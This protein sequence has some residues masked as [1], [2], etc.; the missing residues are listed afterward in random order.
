M[1]RPVLR[2]LSPVF[3][4]S[5]LAALSCDGPPG[6]LAP[7]VAALETAAPAT[8]KPTAVAIP[9]SAPLKAGKPPALLVTTDPERAPEPLGL[10]SV[11]VA[12]VIDGFLAETTT[13][14]TFRN[15]YPRV[16]EGELVFPLPEGATISGYALD[17]AGEMV[18]G[19]AVERHEARIAFEKEVRRGVDPGLVEWVKG[20]NFRTRVWPIPAHGA[21]TVRVRYV[22]ELVTRSRGGAVDAFYALPLRFGQSIADL[23]LKVEVVKGLARPELRSGAPPAFRFEAWE[24]RYVAEARLAGVPPAE[25]LLVALPDVPRQSVRLETDDEGETHFVIVDFPEPPADAPVARPA[26][27]AGIFWDA[28]LSREAADHASELAL[29]DGWLRRVRDIDVDVVVFR[30]VAEAPRAFSVRGGDGRAVREML[31]GLVYDGGTNLGALRFEAGHDYD[32]LFTDGLGTLGPDAPPVPEVPLHAVSADVRANHALLDDIARRS[33]GAYLS[34]QRLGVAEA[35]ESIGARGFSFLSA[36]SAPAAVADLTPAGRRRVQGRDVVAGRLLADEA[37]LTLRY[38][39][40]AASQVRTHTLRKAAATRGRVLSRF[41]AQ[42]RVAELAAQ[43]EANAEELR[44]IG[45]RFGITTPGTSLIVLETLEQ[46]VQHRI[47]PPR[48]R[49]ALR[50]AYERRVVADEASARGRKGDKLG[51]VVEMWRRRVAWWQGRVDKRMP[52]LGDSP[53]GFEEGIAEGVAGGVEGGVPGGVLGGIVGGTAEGAGPREAP[54]APTPRAARPPVMMDRTVMSREEMV[55]VMGYAGGDALAKQEADAA[56]S[57]LPAIVLKPWDPSTPY[58]RV[59]REAGPSGA[60]AAFLS[61]RKAYRTSPAFYLDCADHFLREGARAIG[62]RVL[63]DV[64]ELELEE[65]RLLRIAAHR[66]QRAG[67]LDLAVDLFEKVRRLRPEEPQSLRDLALALE[68]RADARRLR[69][70]KG[71]A[72][73]AA[74]Y[75]RSVE[76]LDEVVAGDWDGR[77]REIEVVAIEEANR[78]IAVVERDRG[79]GRVAFPLDPR[80]RQLLDTDVRIVMTWDTDATDMDLWVREPSGEKCHYAHALTAAGGMLSADLTGGYGPEEYLVRRAPAGPYR[81]QANFYGSSTQ[82][83]TGPTTVQATVITDFGRPGER[84]QALSVRLAR[85][86]EVVDIGTVRFGEEVTQ[87]TR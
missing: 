44:R 35:V 3:A 14:L 19:V 12:V 24:D 33:G 59:L 58:L 80:L 43:P 32:L 46:Y 49:A 50:A 84:R 65:P 61:E 57:G 70:G 51:R 16:L 26:R 81:V 71:D 6:V 37:T 76:L 1:R 25:D 62:L 87:I 68:A 2:R 15:T 72:A 41:W 17:V 79:Y 4:L 60:Y 13:T 21:R 31:E 69:L 28:S 86:R 66:M 42:R 30:D 85:A 5:A 10:T 20:N 54:A 22:S 75:L 55:A 9:V 39:V 29:L 38:G 48:N 47:P 74:D 23:R 8:P 45:Q 7:A 34:L 27:R 73:G 53:V 78:I 67:E 11:D 82:R 83:L 63:T 40:E 77:F 36:Q 52:R 56:S 64:L 18:D